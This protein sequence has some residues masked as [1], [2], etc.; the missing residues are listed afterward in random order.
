MGISARVELNCAAAD[1]LLLR[2]TKFDASRI[3]LSEGPVNE[4]NTFDGD[5]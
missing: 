3:E 2:G 1:K 5:V 4:D